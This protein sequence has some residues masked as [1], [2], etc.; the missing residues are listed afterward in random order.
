V[1]VKGRSNLGN[2]WERR[3]GNRNR[4]LF[5]GQTSLAEPLPLIVFIP[6]DFLFL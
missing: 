3:M 6:L 5:T 1:V 2:L 4:P